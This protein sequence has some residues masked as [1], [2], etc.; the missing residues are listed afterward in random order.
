MTPS[1]TTRRERPEDPAALQAL[2]PILY[3]AWS[4]GHLG[5]DELLAVRDR[6][7]ADDRLFGGDTAWAEAWLDPT[8][9]PTPDELAEI[10]DR[11]RAASADGD[12]VDSL[13]ELGLK[14]ARALGA[15]LADWSE[16]EALAALRELED[17]LGVAGGEAARALVSSPARPSL[18]EPGRAAAFDSA[19][20]N[21]FLDREHRQLRRTLLHR[22]ATPE[23]RNDP[24]TPRAEYR[25]RVLQQLRVL[26]AEGYGSLSY[27]EEFG[28][29]GDP[30]AGVAAFETLAFGDF[31]LLVKYGVQFGLFGGSILNLGT[32]RHHETFL[33]SV[34]ALDLPGCYAMSET[35]HGS[36]VRDLETTATYDR[37]TQEFVVHTPHPLARK[38]WIG[39][40]ALH[41]RL[42]T[43]FAQLLSGGRHYGVHA[44]LV[45]IRDEA[46]RPLPGVTIEDCGHKVGLNGVDNGRIAFDQVRIS[47]DSLLDRFAQMSP[48][49]VYSSPI[50]SEGRRFFTMLGTL[51]A[52]R[53][54]VACASLS[55]S[56][57]AL[58]I[59]IRYADQ[60]RQFGP[61]GGSERP[62]LDYLTLQR[63]LLPRL[64]TTYALHFA[65]R[66]LQKRFGSARE[67]EGPEIEV[68]AAGLKAIASTH[69]LETVQACREACG[70]KG[71][72]AENRFGTLRNDTDV[73]T[74]FEG[75]NPVLL[76]LVAKGLLSRYKREMGD[77]NVWG[78]VRYLADRAGTRM[79]ELNPVVTR[80]TDRAHLLDPS[81]HDA[82][83]RWRAEHLLSTVAAR[84]KSRID[85]GT[86]SFEAL[87]EC[88]DHVVELARAHV[89]LVL[90]ERFQEAVRQ[91]PAG[92]SEVL[93]ELCALFALATM[94]RQRG[95]YLESG[96]MESVKTKAIRAEVNRLCRSQRDRALALVDAFGIPDSL[97][98]APAAFVQEYPAP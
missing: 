24:E 90:L 34:G 93:E 19:A 70:G 30:A 51:V 74:T 50:A 15:Q 79:A 91:A 64:A 77:L 71:Y 73:F 5:P 28:G 17:L 39:N 96:Y 98:S 32:R 2:L 20:L 61:E 13:A 46:G 85:A 23:F 12:R 14:T 67:E 52:G 59:A 16:P 68:L 31:S 58:A 9:P 82:A 43:V 45:W 69:N 26:A 1:T 6:I 54:S 42:A 33:R 76:Q 94:E 63:A 83:I 87:N 29:R 47:R 84:L 18:A 35:R 65:L 97:L 56:K 81:F 21:E 48:E 57:T 78:I 62:I 41:G 8:H 66:D 37:K 75:A 95:W 10:R 80:R 38:D 55:A 72:L 3:V 11:I 4:D 36:N 27:P 25:A 60:R 89:D 22:L 53:V 40:A 86:D 92:L 44:F 49:G 7:R 88:Q